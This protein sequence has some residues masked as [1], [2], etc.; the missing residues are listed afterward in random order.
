MTCL[1]PLSN[2]DSLLNTGKLVFCALI[3]CCELK[4]VHLFSFATFRNEQAAAEAKRVLM[5]GSLEFKGLKLDAN[6][7]FDKDFT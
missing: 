2:R 1:S 4:V 6:Y 5:S 7:A 3:C